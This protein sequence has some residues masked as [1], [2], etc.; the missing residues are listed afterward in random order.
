MN[1]L[2]ALKAGRYPKDE[3]G[4]QVVTTRASRCAVIYTVNYPGKYPILG[5]VDGSLRTWNKEG[6]SYESRNE[7]SY[8][9]MP[10]KTIYKLNVC[11]VI[12]KATN[13]VVYLCTDT[14]WDGRNLTQ[15]RD[16]PEY[17]L[18]YRIVEG[19]VPG[20]VDWPNTDRPS[21][22]TRPTSQTS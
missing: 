22:P 19:E 6:Y 8:D 20:P 14:D 18:L 4:N 7:L 10:P 5:L 1:I 3:N 16:D 2:E 21:G 15:Y 11:F 13:K 12:H 17:T 9:L